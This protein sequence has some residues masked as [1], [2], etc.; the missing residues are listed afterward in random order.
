[1][2]QE[3]EGSSPHSQK[4][5]ESNP[6]PPQANLPKIRCDSIFPPTP[7]SSKW[8]ISFGLSHQIL[9]HFWTFCQICLFEFI[10]MEGG[11]KF[12][13]QFKMGKL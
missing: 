8:S 1:V 7:W 5:V 9:V 10:R 6:P 4:P 13:K 11:V 2:A 12:M 3:P